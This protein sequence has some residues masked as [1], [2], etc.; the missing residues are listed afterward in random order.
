M[1]DDRIRILT[2][3][4]SC[5]RDARSHMAFT[6]MSKR[7]R[8]SRAPPPSFAPPVHFTSQLNALAALKRGNGRFQ[9]RH[10]FQLLTRSTFVFMALCL[11]L[12]PSLWFSSP[13][14]DP[15]PAFRA[16][17][18]LEQG[19]RTLL[20]VPSRNGVGT[21]VAEETVPPPAVGVLRVP[22]AEERATA[23]WIMDHPSTPG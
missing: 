6:M 12:A 18:E 20:R 2:S 1:Y 11:L 23:A 9:A 3:Q 14:T 16:E 17:L 22:T 8:R 7:H 15:S 21:S 13:T 19:K 4:P 10:L 5:T